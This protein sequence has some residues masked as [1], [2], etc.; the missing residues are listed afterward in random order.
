MA[1]VDIK[2]MV[3]GECDAALSRID[4]NDTR[5]LLGMLAEADQVF[6]VGVGR[7]MLALQCVCKRF[8]HLGVK[9]HVVGEITEPA[10]TDGDL[11]F[12]GSGSGESLVPKAIAIKAKSLGAK[13]AHIGANAEGTIARMADLFIRIPVQTKLDRDDELRSGQPMTSLFEQCLLLYGDIL[14]KMYIEERNIDMKSL[15]RFHANLE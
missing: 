15:W 14:A 13:I 1:Y 7:V 6:F 11:L 10:L 3:V 2:N 4:E 5:R 8:A 9:T 12:V